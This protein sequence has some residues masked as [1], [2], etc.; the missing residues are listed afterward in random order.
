MIGNRCQSVIVLFL[1]LL[2]C[3]LNSRDFRSFDPWFPL[4]LM[5][6]SLVSWLQIGR[7]FPVIFKYKIS[8]NQSEAVW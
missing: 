8:E 6:K 5:V 2:R 4:Y 1:V 7:L 3:R